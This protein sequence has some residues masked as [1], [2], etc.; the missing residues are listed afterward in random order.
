MAR[1]ARVKDSAVLPL[2]DGIPAQSLESDPRFDEGYSR[3]YD[4]TFRHAGV[5]LTFLRRRDRG[6]WR[7]LDREDVCL[8]IGFGITVL[9]DA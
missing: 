4:S 3:L 6:W 7:R 8:P 5:Q 9:G 2:S 1:D